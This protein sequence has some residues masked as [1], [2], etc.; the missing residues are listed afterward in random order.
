MDNISLVSHGLKIAVLD[1][2]EVQDADIAFIVQEE[3]S[4]Q[5]IHPENPCSPSHF[6]RAIRQCIEVCTRLCS[7]RNQERKIFYRTP[8]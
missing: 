6:L 7:F 1:L 3:W 4:S 8:Q 5:I 2:I